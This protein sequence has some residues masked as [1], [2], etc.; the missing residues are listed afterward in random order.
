MR[1]QIGL[2]LGGRDFRLITPFKS[3]IV[4]GDGDADG[5]APPGMVKIAFV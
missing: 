4:G 1:W 2:W 3:I 5:K